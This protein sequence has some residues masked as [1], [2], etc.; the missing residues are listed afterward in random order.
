MVKP[1]RI[2]TKDL[3]IIRLTLPDGR[4]VFQRRTEDAPTSPGLLGFFGGHLEE[5]EK[6]YDGAKRELGEE[7]SIK[8]TTGLALWGRFT[9][10]SPEGDPRKV[11]V[12]GLAVTT[13]D[14]DIYEGAGVEVYALKEVLARDDVALNL[15]LILEGKV[16][17]EL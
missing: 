4:L 6:A 8:N 10:I 16:Q 7:T 15:R 9:T 14:F 2:E 13:A 11:H 12:Y 5:G 3:A 1:S 17:N